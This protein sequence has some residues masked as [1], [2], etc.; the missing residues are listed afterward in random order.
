MA[1]GARSRL[2]GPLAA[3]AWVA[4]ILVAGSLGVLGLRI[5]GGSS[6]S[7]DAVLSSQQA[8]A[9]ATAPA[10]GGA[11]TTSPPATVAATSPPDQGGGLTRRT[12]PGAVL[13]LT[14]DGSVPLLVWSVP[15]DGWRVEGSEAEDETLRVRLRSEDAEVRVEIVCQLG[16]PQVVAAERDDD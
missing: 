7:R 2:P 9:L 8:L 4:A 13:G 3:V 11:T 1:A 14:C 12:V 6:T 10:P 5:A 15:E 16:S